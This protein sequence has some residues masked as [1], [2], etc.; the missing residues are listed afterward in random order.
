M[1]VGQGDS[2][3]TRKRR[4]CQISKGSNKFDDFH[5][6]SDKTMLPGRREGTLIQV[7]KLVSSKKNER[8]MNVDNCS[9]KKD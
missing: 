8:F 3:F 5:K 6:T 9:Q 7:T 2:R 1:A 4:I